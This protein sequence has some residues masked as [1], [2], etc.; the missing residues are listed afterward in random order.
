MTGHRFYELAVT[1]CAAVSDL[2]QN[3]QAG[4]L[5]DPWKACKRMVDLERTC[6]ASVWCQAPLE[7]FTACAARYSEAEREVQCA[8]HLESL[9]TC[10]QL[11]DEQ[12]YEDETERN[13]SGTDDSIPET[14][15]YTLELDALKMLFLADNGPRWKPL[16]Q[17]EDW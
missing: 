15:L 14:E 17:Q 4:S 11:S 3:C 12:L 8:H 10:M 7:K 5:S 6:F 13:Y 9:N 2:R 16:H 1:R